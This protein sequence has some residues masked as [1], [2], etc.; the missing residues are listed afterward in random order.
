MCLRV[1]KS[2]GT[3]LARRRHSSSRKT[4]PKTQCMR[5][6]IV[7]KGTDMRGRERQRGDVGAGLALGPAASLA[8]ALDHDEAHQAG[9][10]VAFPQPGDVVDDG[11]GAGLDSAVVAVDGFVPADGSVLETPAAKSSASSRSEPWLPI[12]AWI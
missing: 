4:M 10:K 5:P 7:D 3:W 9:P 8:G 6:V 1:V 2:A 11:D 12:R